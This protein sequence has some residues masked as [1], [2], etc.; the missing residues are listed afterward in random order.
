MFSTI[1]TN[2]RCGHP[3]SI[4]HRIGDLAYWRTDGCM[5]CAHLRLLFA[6]IFIGAALV[7]CVG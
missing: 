2:F 6:G 7:A 4:W 3:N 5:C 1:L